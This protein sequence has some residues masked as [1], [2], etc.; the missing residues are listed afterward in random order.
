MTGKKKKEAMVEEELDPSQ[1]ECTVCTYQNKAE[2]FKCEMCDTR[3][4]TSTRKPKL[5]ENVVAIH[6]VVQNF[7]IQHSTP[8][9]NRRSKEFSHADSPTASSSR[10]SPDSTSSRDSSR[11]SSSQKRTREKRKNVPLP[12]KLVFRTSPTKR[13]FTV[14]GVKAVIQVFRSR[15][16]AKLRVRYVDDP[17]CTVDP[18]RGT[19]AVTEPTLT[20]SPEN[21]AT[22]QITE[23]K[24]EEVKENVVLENATV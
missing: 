4:G 16:A 18:G 21:S 11:P 14:N 19:V 6:Q 3:K 20:A 10:L 24:T 15:P 22:L 13:E 23:I 17:E 5:N 8:K 9:A 2:A 12:D 7:A 1:W